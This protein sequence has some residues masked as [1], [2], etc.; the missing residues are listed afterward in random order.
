MLGATGSS[1]ATIWTRANGEYAVDVLLA[2]DKYFRKPAL[3]SRLV[4]KRQNDFVNVHRIT[5]LQAGTRY[6]YRILV[7]QGR[8]LGDWARRIPDQAYLPPFEFRTAPDPGQ[9]SVFRIAFGSC[10]R[11]EAD[12]Q[13]PIWDAVAMWKPDLFFWLGD[14]IYA[15]SDSPVV[16]ADQYRRQRAVGSMQKVLRT[17]PQLAIWDDHDYSRND[18]DRTSPVKEASLQIFKQYWANPAYGQR[19][20][21]GIFFQ[22]SYGGVDFFFL[23]NRYYRDPNDRSDGANKTMLGKQQKD[24]LKKGLKNSTAPFKLLIAGGGWS[25]AKGTA[26]DS[27]AAFLTER[28]EIFSFIHA[29]QISGVVLLSGDTHFGELNAI[30]WSENGGYDFYDLVSSPLAQ[31]TSSAYINQE[32]ELRIRTPYSGSTNF[33]V[34]DFDMKAKIPSLE[35]QLV[36]VQGGSVWRPFSLRAD[37]LVNGKMSW[38]TKKI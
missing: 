9:K 35:F 36:N 1:D 33:G 22:Y 5:G 11:I 4:A 19:D 29:N 27:W 24:W 20:V 15:D 10:A 34:V 18:H 12:W 17:T 30:P 28:N 7:N 38:Q 25:K 13:Q 3:A 14:N 23:D 8:H 31:N 26:M 2:A 16:I 6:F 37:E 32:P 21:P